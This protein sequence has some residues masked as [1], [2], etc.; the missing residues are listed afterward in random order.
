[1]QEYIV[2][3]DYEQLPISYLKDEWCSMLKSHKLNADKITKKDAK[4]LRSLFRGWLHK[5]V[6]MFYKIDVDP[7]H[8]HPSTRERLPYAK[9]LYEWI[10]V[11]DSIL[12]IGCGVNILLIPSFDRY[13]GVDLMKSY[14]DLVETNGGESF[15]HRADDPIFLKRLPSCDIS[16]MFKLLDLVDRQGHKM[17]ESMVD[18]VPCKVVIISF[19]TKTL[20][21]KPMNHP[22]RGWVL[23]MCERRGWN[24]EEKM[25]YNEVYYRVTKI[26]A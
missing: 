4:L 16:F 9:E 8:D 23:R 14:L 20:S 6:G 19:P 13:I 15:H 21:G 17:A 11:T 24:V 12:D 26:S 5:R 10:G 22:Q 7:V 3:T 1:M 2:G 25:F 18:A